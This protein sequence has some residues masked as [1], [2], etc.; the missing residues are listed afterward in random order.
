MTEPG[1]AAGLDRCAPAPDLVVERRYSVSQLERTGWDGLCAR[2]DFYQSS[3]WLALVE[4]RMHGIPIYLVARPPDG[5]P[6]LAGLACYPFGESTFPPLVR[7]DLVVSRSLPAQVGSAANG[8]AALARDLLPSLHCGGRQM[9]YSGLLL[10]S[11]IPATERRRVADRMLAAVERVARELAMGSI[12]FPY[13]ARGD[14]L[15]RDRL[16]ANGYTEFFSD[17]RSHLEL[18]CTDFEGYLAGFNKHR[19]TSIRREVRHLEAAGL[20]YEE[21]PLSEAVVAELA[22]L[23]DNLLRRHGVRRTTGQVSRTLCDLARRFESM[24]VVLAAVHGNQTRGFAALVRW[25]DELYVRNVGFDYDFQAKLPLYFGVAFYE[26]V[27]YA[28]RH[29]LRHIEYGPGSDATK[30]SRGCR[31]IELFGYVRALRS[32]A[33]ER[34]DALLQ[35][36]P[37]D[38]P[39]APAAAPPIPVGVSPPLGG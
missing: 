32:G 26:P 1:A 30:A 9:S 18:D 31:V 38:A 29:N 39:R 35:G 13:V 20:H 5:G 19:R 21:R 27:R 3:E 7:I 11:R 36:A 33:Q 10:S 34:L 23:E 22:A 4:E 15:L 6:P 17:Y 16:A 2:G 12:S 25:R 8:R 24:G 37:A 14:E 28:L